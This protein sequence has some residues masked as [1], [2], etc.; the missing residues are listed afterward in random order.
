MFQLGTV[1][2]QMCID[3]KAY[4]QGSVRVSVQNAVGSALLS[5]SLSE[6][7]CTPIGDFGLQLVLGQGFAIEAM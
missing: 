6:T 1:R 7:G 2:P 3:T 5:G 4:R